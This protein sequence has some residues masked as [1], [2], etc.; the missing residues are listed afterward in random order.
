MTEFGT[1]GKANKAKPKLHEAY[2]G[3]CP[4]SYNFN[5]NIVDTSSLYTLTL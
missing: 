3:A 2:S 4:I 1:N 5:L